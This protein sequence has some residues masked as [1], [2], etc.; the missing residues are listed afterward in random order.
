MAFLK[1]MQISF[2]SLV[3]KGANNRTII[4]KS[5]D[6]PPESRNVAI[7]K[8]D[9]EKRMVYGVVYSPDEKDLQGDWTTAQE[10]EKAAYDFMRSLSLH[11]VDRSHSWTP[12]GAYVA[13]SWLIRKGD[14]LFPAEKPGSWAVGIKVEKPEL[15][16]EVKKGDISALSM[17]GSGERE[18][19]EIEKSE[20]SILDAIRKYFNKK[21][22]EIVMDKTEVEKI[23]KEAMAAGP[24]PL[25][26][27]E[28][29]VVVKAALEASLKP[30]TD[31]IEA[32][33]KQ[34][35]G[36]KQSDEEVKKNHDD[37]VALGSQIAKMVNDNKR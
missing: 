4:W 12:E 16:A 18:D 2:I 29:G 27:E 14:E 25:T 15:W 13:E 24:K 31:R 36:S 3:R 17:V 6:E 33:E 23:V 1:N 28:M 34:S 7:A 35:P 20:K 26:V 5:A 19:R 21:G 10:I 11:N 30:V 8:I 32:I 9:D 22:E 37:L